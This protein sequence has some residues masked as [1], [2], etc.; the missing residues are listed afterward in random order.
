MLA[1]K[2]SIFV[3]LVVLAFNLSAC[4]RK[5]EAEEKVEAPLRVGGR[6]AEES[7]ET[8][9]SLSYPGL[10]AADSEATIVA[11]SSGNFT[12]FRAQVGDRVFLG[13]ELARIDDINSP[14]AAGQDFSSNQI[15]QAR[16]AVSSAAAA[17]AQAKESYNNLLISAV[18]D[19]RAAE[20]ARDQAVKSQG[21][22]DITAGD[23]LK[24]A[25]IAYETARIASAQAA[26][27][28]AS[29]QRLASQALRDAETNA[30]LAANSVV[31]TAG[32]ILTNINNLTGFDA[33]NTVTISYRTNLGALDSSVYAP[34]KQAYDDAR[35][36]YTEHDWVYRPAVV[37]RV[38]AALSLAEKVALAADTTK[39]LFNKTTTSSDLPQSSPSGPSLSGLQSAI[40]GYQTQAHAA[41]AQAVASSQALVNVRLN[42]DSLIESL[43][44]AQRLAQQQEASARQN[45]ASLQ[46]GNASQQTQA[47][48]AASLAQN[49]YENARVKIEA[50]L[51]AAR[52]QM[53]TAQI[54]HQN[55]SVALDALYDAHSVVAPIDGTVTKVFVAA[56]QAVSPGQPLITISQVESIKIHF[57]VEAE[58]LSALTAGLP[59]SVTDSSGQSFAGVV[60]GVSPQADPLTRRFLAEVRLENPAGLLLGTVVDV[61]VSLAQRTSQPGHLLLPLSAV[62]VGQNGSHI[63]IIRDNRAV[64]TAVE[65]RQVKGEYAEVAVDLEPQTFIITEGNRLLQD[66]QLVSLQ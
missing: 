25:Q 55:A 31:A 32:A 47:G 23:N 27:T 14:V 8:A 43:Q 10:V 20:I 44:Q 63:F 12:G 59:V 13:Q 21:Q 22:L 4:A 42:N 28:L 29:R 19:L 50:Q 57:Y 15:K 62:T 26:E 56:G 45:L 34:A 17:Y 6:T 24:S 58:N 66:G 7:R 1:K 33:N 53:E 38:Q 60:A 41:V 2:I 37:D 61:H 30:D 11:K 35:K 52:T 36:A 40:S 48:Y 9:L 54:Q 51:G 18:K 16:L 5:E 46:S 65:I 64:R 39:I 3:L 49:Q